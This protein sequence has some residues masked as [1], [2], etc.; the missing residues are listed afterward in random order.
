MKK[1]AFFGLDNAGKTSIILGIN[2][3]FNYIEEAKSLKPTTKVER[4]IFRF[5]DSE[6]SQHDFGGQAK[7][8]KE[9]LKNKDRF[10]NNTDLIFYVIDIQDP[11][12]FELS[13]QYFD[14][15]A[16]Y[17]QEDGIKIPIVILF[18][19]YDPEMKSN[20]EVLQHVYDLKK[21]FNEWLPFHNI[22]YFETTIYDLFSIMQAFSFGMSQLFEVSEV[23]KKLIADIGKKFETIGLLLFNDDGIPIAQY[24]LDDLDEIKRELIKA[25]FV[26]TQ[27]L[28]VEKSSD[29]YEFSD[30]L[31]VDE[32]VSG[33][34][35]TF[36][37]NSRRYFILYAVEEV[38]E[39]KTIEYLNQ[40]EDFR[41]RLG[42]ILHSMLDRKKAPI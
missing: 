27:E 6:I 40:F 30:W 10:L 1:I 11:D 39:D 15:I 19:K 29:L 21:K 31:S 8:R 2:R 7:Y 34:I 12:R 41:A 38:E 35:E 16:K 36:I 20:R 17:F 33:V 37:I 42:E 14:E 26:N 5:L 3:K 9:Y 28:L 13:T 25:L 24:Y 22:Y 23:L 4:S 18:H 32:R